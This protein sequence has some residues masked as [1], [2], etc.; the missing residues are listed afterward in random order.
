MKYSFQFLK[1]L[2]VYQKKDEILE[3]IRDNQVVIISGE[4]G[5]ENNATAANMSGGWFWK[6]G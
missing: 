6:T 5:P 4:T 2:P 3:A 1:N